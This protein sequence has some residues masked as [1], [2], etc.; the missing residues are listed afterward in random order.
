MRKSIFLAISFLLLLSFTFI[1]CKT[2]PD[3]PVTEEKS[4]LEPAATPSAQPAAP[5]PEPAPSEP[6]PAPVTPKV[7]LSALW[8]LMGKIE[9]A[10]TIA[11]DFEGNSYFPSEWEYAEFDYNIVRGISA[12][13]KRLSELTESDAA[14]GKEWL[15]DILDTYNGVFRKSIPLYAQAREDE[16]MALRERLFD[17]GLVDYYPKY[18][19]SAD[20]K[21]LAALDQYEAEDYY[22]ARDTAVKAMDEYEALLLGAIIILTR[23]ELVITGL[24]Q[25]YPEY[26]QS[27]DKK[28]IAALDQYEADEYKTARERG[29]IALSEYEILLMGARIVFKIDE[30]TDTGLPYQYPEYLTYADSLANDAIDQYDTDNYDTAR[31]S[32][33]EAY[34]AYDDLLTAAIIYFRRQEILERG[35]YVYD[36]EN[37]DNAD[38]IAVS[39]I[40]LYEDGNKIGAEE[41]AAEVLLRYNILLTN[42][43]VSYAADRRTFAANERDMAI[44]ERVNI[45]M[46]DAFREAED[47]YNHAE[48]LFK[49]E[50]YDEA[51]NLYTD[52]EALFAI[53]RLD[54]AER[55]RRAQEA[56]RTAEIEIEG[57]RGAAI[58]AER[59][60]EGGSR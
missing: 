9:A 42:G 18:L 50:R 15:N 20:T 49:A 21:A 31:N 56:I 37:F 46:R 6:P 51:A 19:R 48:E 47:I 40:F 58:Q 52:A 3:E 39:A 55:R 35:F 57:S 41:K 16:I 11:H 30:L 5:A 36:T 38:E 10:R 34:V 7:D 27:A 4:A 12:D 33:A 8:D 29:V 59:I 24:T 1:A 32:A 60:F 43:W 53:N 13:E 54:T 2:V 23:D 28:A 45:A 17:T 14:E 22:L 44:N 26:L 25:L